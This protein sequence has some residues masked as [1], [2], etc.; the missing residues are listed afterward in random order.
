VRGIEHLYSHQAAALDALARQEHVLAVTPTASGKSLVYQVPA[1]AAAL[2]DPEARSLFLFP[3]KALAQDQIGALHDLAVEARPLAPP[4]AAIYDGDTKPATRKRIRERPPSILLTNPDM[5]HLALLPH[6]EAWS[7]L[8]ASLRYVVVDEMHAYRGIFGAHLHHVLRRLRRLCRLHGSSPRFIVASATMANPRQHAEAILGVP[9]TE[10]GES[11]APRAAR[12]FLLLDP[13]ASPY[14]AAAQ[15]LTAAMDAGLRTIVFTKARRITELIYA[16]VAAER[17]DLRGR[18]AAY[19]AGYLPEERRE[20]EQRLFRGELMGVVS[21][22]ALELGVDIGGLDVCIIVGYPGSQVQLWQRVGR[23]GRREQESLVV[24]VAMPDALDQYFLRHPEALFGRPLERAIVD[25]ANPAIHAAHLICAA[26]EHP[27]DLA[28]GEPELLA[29]SLEVAAGM[30]GRGELSLDAEGRRFHTRR[31][32]PQREV[33]LRSTGASLAIVEA[34]SGRPIGQIDASRA[35]RETHPGAIYLHAGGQYEVTSFDRDLRQVEVVRSTAD[36]YTEVITEK[37]TEILEVLRDEARLGSRAGLGRLR[38][39]E[40]VR[41]YHRRR[42]ASRELVSTHPLDLPPLIFETVGLWLDLPAALRDE[43]EGSGGDFPGAIHALEHAAIGLFPLL[44]IADRSDLGGISYP[45][46]PQIGRPVVFIYDGHPGGIGLAAQ[47]FEGLDRLLAETRDLIAACR[48]GGGCPSCVQSPKC[49]NGNRPLDREGALLLLR[50]LTGAAPARGARPP[51]PFVL[52]PASPGEQEVRTIH[53]VTPAPRGEAGAPRTAGRVLAFD[54]ETRRSA[55][56]VGG[57]DQAA[58]MGLALA[59]LEDLATGEARAYLEADAPT[60]LVD[61]LSADLVVGY[62]VKRFD[63]AV[64]GAYAPE[65]ALRRVPTLDL[66]EEIHRVLG[67]RVKLA[68]VAAATLGVTKSADGLQSLEWFREGRLDLIEE[69]CR[70]D[71][72]LTADLYRFGLEQG[73]LLYPD[74]DGQPMRVAASWKRG[75]DVK[76]R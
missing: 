75:A 27:L 51:A 66:L 71:V 16:W 41:G 70:R 5:L 43:V 1:L 61:L 26:S 46:H 9:L 13:P 60:L 11:G 10:I 64:L 63:Y 37:E 62:N 15:L 29:G 59:V 4:A 7:T 2:D 25:P 48:C 45:F 36:T 49:G 12:H 55:E 34:G 50:I 20:I 22:S 18:L 57:W 8:F 42:I 44:A 17:H 65:G 35:F 74:R 3:F 21:T 40:W 56:E 32:R 68:A 58:Q 53:P 39:T 33:D 19:R 28:T 31:R 52:P 47:G 69:Y 67:F 6:H 23:V 30:A 24:L 14:T 54:L 76:V 72:R 38:V 73:Y